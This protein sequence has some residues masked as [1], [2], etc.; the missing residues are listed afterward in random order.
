MNVINNKLIII[1][2]YYYVLQRIKKNGV[3]NYKDCINF[4]FCY[5]EISKI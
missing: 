3:Y 2:Y 5:N 4:F 1:Y